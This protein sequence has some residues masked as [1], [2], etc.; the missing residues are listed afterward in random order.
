MPSLRNK[1]FYTYGF[2]KLVL[3]AFAA[4]VFADLYYLSRQI[5]EGQAVADFREATLEMR[6]DEKNLFLYRDIASLDQLRQQ[7]DMAEATL[8]KGRAVF[9][10]IGGE[11]RFLHIRTLLRDYLHALEGYPLLDRA[12]Q[13]DARKSIRDLGHE[14]TETSH[15]LRRNERRH[16]ADATR[17]AGLTLLLA[18]A[19][20]VVL[21]VAGGLFLAHGVARPL[22][23]L[24]TG[25]R[26]I[27]E[28]RAR[29][30]ALPSR[31]LEIES[32]VASFNTMLKHMRQ[33]QDQVKRS[34]KA[35]ALGVLVS[36]VAHELNNPLSNIS[37]SVQLLMEEDASVDTETRAIWLA[38][39]DGETERA[40]RIVRRLLD[41]VRQPK[42][43]VQRLALADLLQ[44]SLSLVH[45]QLPAHVHV[46]VEASAELEIAVDRERI[47]QVFINLIKNAADAG[48]RHIQISAEQEAWN[49]DQVGERHLEGDPAI[50]AQSFR[51]MR[52]V[53]ADDGPGIAPEVCGHL[54]EPF[55]TTRS[56]GEG[57]GLGLYLVEEIISEH[58]GCIVVDCSAGSGTRFEI[59]LPLPEERP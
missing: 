45:R 15:E 1:I 29:E 48:A 59:W 54:F 32:F 38:Q 33:Q 4:V 34:E 21:G 10:I 6:R 2:S 39:I 47:H 36:G 5:E 42:L 13:A 37:T 50:L 31:D 56:S 12:A 55:V 27:D 57:T 46:C 3:L 17:R 44:S 14:L 7:A 51:A 23:G 18:F 25:L 35:A 53:V 41:S 28:G 52:I 20:V 58:R 11:A 19:G 8:T 43:H 9:L 40:R 24:Q 26:D 22:R 30:L 49:A 16:L